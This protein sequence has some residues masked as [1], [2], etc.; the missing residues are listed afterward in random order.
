MANQPKKYKKFVATAAT[1]T[2]VASAIVPVASAKSFSDVAENNEFQPFI[3]AL[4]DAGIINGYPDGTFKPGAKLTRGQVVKMLGRW[5]ESNGATVPTDWETVQR[6]NDVPVNSADKELVKYAA[7][8]KDEGVFTGS[9]G[10][11]MAGNNITRQ[12][13]AKVLNGAFTAVNGTSLVDL[14]DKIDNKLVTDLASAQQEFEGYIQALVDLEISTVSVFRPSEN[15][16][17][18]QFA[19]FLYNT[20]ELEA[21]GAAG[22]KAINNTTVEVTFDTDVDNIEAL[23]FKIEGLE[24]SSAVVKQTDKKTVVLTTAAQEG[25]KKYTVSVNDEEVGTFTG[26]AAVIPTA[27]KITTPS[28]QGTT[29][30]EVT[31]KAE[32]TVPEGQSKAGIPVT[33][34]IPAQGSLA[35]AI[36][37]EA[38]TDANGV[39]TYSYTRYTG[40]TDD[41]IAYATGDRSKFSA[42]KVYWASKLAISEVTTGVEL[43]NNDKKVYKVT[44]APGQRINI[45]FKENVDVTA[46][47]LVRDVTV[48]AGTNISGAGLF[49]YQI[50]GNGATQAVEIVLDSKGEGS[51]TVSGKNNAVTPFVW[52]DSAS[53][54]SVV[55][56]FYPVY[57][58]DGVTVDYYLPRYSSS[59]TGNDR[60]AATELNAVAATVKFSDILYYT[61][62]V[63]G[64]KS[65]QAAYDYGIKG[66][67]GRDY[68]VTLAHTDGTKAVKGEK[69]KVFLDE[70]LS[71]DRVYILNAA[72]AQV[73][74]S[75]GTNN[76]IELTVDEK[77]QAKFTVYSDATSAQAATLEY[78]TPVVFIDR[79]NDFTLDKT[80][81]SKTAELVSFKAAVETSVSVKYYNAAGKEVTS[82]QANVD[83]V[84]VRLTVLDQNDKVIKNTNKQQATFTVYNNSAS[85]IIVNGGAATSHLPTSVTD[86]LSNGVAEITLK[87]TGPISNLNVRGSYD[88]F[89]QDATISFSN[90]PGV[91]IRSTVDSVDATADNES[92]TFADG[93]K[94]YLD[95]L[96]YKALNSSLE[97]TTAQSFL[98]DAVTKGEVIEYNPT[99]KTIT[100]TD[101]DGTGEGAKATNPNPTF[102]YTNI[103]GTVGTAIATTT[104]T[105]TGATAVSFTAT[106]ALPAGLT[107]NP[108]TGAISGT[109]TAVTASAPFT[110]K[111]VYTDA[112]G[113]T[114]DKTATVTINVVAAPVVTGITTSLATTQGSAVVPASPATGTIILGALSANDTVTV[115]G[116]VYTYVTTSPAADQ[117]TNATELA[118]LINADSPTTGLTASA[119]SVIVTVSDATGANTAT[120][121]T[122]NSTE[123]TLSGATLT[124]GTVATGTNVTESAL[125]TV[126][127][128]ATA[129]GSL[130]VTLTN[131]AKTVTVAVTSGQ[132]ATQVA[133][134]IVAALGTV[135]GYNVT[136]N[137]NGTITFTSTTANTNVAD[138][139]VT[140]TNN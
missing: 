51:F 19:K 93:T 76:V 137:G 9:N 84:T 85:G 7:L 75:D 116:E 117:F 68:V 6:F 119:S 101:T 48:I 88:N 73:R 3:D 114:F 31:V 8:V 27:L 81:I 82:A 56:G 54:T 72:G 33:F 129:T 80:D 124:G 10:N 43:A 28:I 108:T 47:K 37:A 21:V 139:T 42:G 111:A 62:N 125:L 132:T 71:S 98:K 44:G 41:V 63:E 74:P 64:V 91:T 23:D 14:A 24:V 5:V 50:A 55:D 58:S 26:I 22:V 135:T 45:G 15:V 69:V 104:P 118:A 17:R 128:P 92:I 105:F 140:V 96:T 78:A 59:T 113:Y 16:T 34:N 106:T 25:G 13:M 53:T 11:L 102:S 136:D 83:T 120:L 100:V 99:T 134:A 52:D 77:G 89:V 138:L 67:G 46:D 87:S 127:G 94:V 107:L 20:I 109:P 60:F 65:A 90:N 4:S 121:A 36:T 110:I 86:I 12:Q 97:F 126:T 123:V 130:T 29:G 39:A 95:G 35:A 57:K 30:K 38:T 18:A 66:D 112:Q 49:P 131:P 79:D 32:V 133:A 40:V 115:D 1:A 2:L 103:N 122:S 61:I 70:D